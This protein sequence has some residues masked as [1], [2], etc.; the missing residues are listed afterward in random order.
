[1]DNELKQYLAEM[2]GRLNTRVEAVEE[3]INARIEKSET[4]LLTAFHGWA[5]AMEIRV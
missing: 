3:R 2:E 1:M 4:N 5:R